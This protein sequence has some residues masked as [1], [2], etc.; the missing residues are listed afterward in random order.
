MLDRLDEETIVL[1]MSD[2]GFGPLHAIVNLNNYL[3]E[4]GL[5]HLKRDPWTRLKA[6]AFRRGLTPATIFRWMSRLGVQ[7]LAARTSK[8]TRNK[9]MG[10]L[11]SYDAVDWSRTV[12][13]SMGHVGQI[14]L[15]IAGR[16][17]NGIV[18]PSDR[19]R[20]LQQVMDALQEL[21]DEAGRPLVT[22]LIPRRDI[23]HGRHA[24]HGPDLHVVLDDYKMISFPLF[25]TDSSII[26]KQIRGDSG[27]HRREGVFIASGPGIRRGT[28]LARASILDLAPTILHLAGLPVPSVMDGRVLGDIFKTPPDV[29]H[30]ET[31]PE[32]RP[33]TGLDETES[34][35]VEERLRGLGYL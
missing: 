29:R 3:M 23:Y 4:K 6:A 11:L 8:A 15:N 33:E 7:D 14:Y 12:A 18:S 28:T 30:T 26:T 1:V 24:E 25:A 9:M 16:E 27:C 31:Q 22:R 17:P 35:E 21:R 13:Y 5:L 34:A 2:H 10:K 32:I 20:V 19:P